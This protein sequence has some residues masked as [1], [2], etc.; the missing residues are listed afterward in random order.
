MKSSLIIT[1]Y[2]RPDALELVFLSLLQ[3]SLLPDEIIVADDGSTDETLDIINKYRSK[4]NTDIN[5]VWQKNEGFRAARIRNLAIIKSQGDY[6][7]FI[8]GDMILHKDFTKSHIVLAEKN[9]FI[10]G[11]RVL[12]NGA[13]TSQKLLSKSIKIPFFTFKIKNR[14][15]A[16]HNVFLAKIFS[17][18][19]NGIKG[20]KTCNFSCWKKDAIMV[21]GFN[22]DFIGW[23][24]EDSEFSIRLLNQNINRKDLRFCGVAFHL[25]HQENNKNTI[26]ENYKKN[27]ALLDF[28]IKNNLSYCTNGIKKGN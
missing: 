23:G 4:F 19:I 18:R 6:L 10:Q 17:R 12:I 2:N 13:L 3:Q 27:L 9:Y 15:N 11:H 25:D 5:H 14:I 1:T 26:N 7:I 16:I 22:E 8:D 21:N 24:K 20:I 28:A